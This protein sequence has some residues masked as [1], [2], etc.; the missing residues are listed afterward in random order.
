MR[1]SSNDGEPGRT[2]ECGLKEEAQKGKDRC[3]RPYS[4]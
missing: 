4:E 3:T 2:G 1:K